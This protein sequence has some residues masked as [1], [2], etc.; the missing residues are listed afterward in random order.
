MILSA[1]SVLKWCVNAVWNHMALHT[2]FQM[3]SADYAFI[4]A[5]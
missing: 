3:I 1:G 2:G 4:I 5:K